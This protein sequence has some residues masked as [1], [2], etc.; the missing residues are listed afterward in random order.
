LILYYIISFAYSRL[1]LEAHGLKH[2]EHARKH[3]HSKKNSNLF[4]FLTTDETRKKEQHGH[5]G[6]DGGSRRKSNQEMKSIQEKIKKR[7]SNSTNT[8]AFGRMKKPII[9]NQRNQNM[10]FGRRRNSTA[11]RESFMHLHQGLSATDFM[12]GTYSGTKP[13]Y[14]H[15]LYQHGDKE[16]VS[17]N[18]RQVLAHVLED[19]GDKGDYHRR[20]YNHKGAL[21]YKEQT[22]VDLHDSV[23]MLEAKL[24]A[25]EKELEVHTSRSPKRSTSKK[26]SAAE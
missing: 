24:S 12:G 21:I 15:I 1:G 14:N 5:N 16:G 11:T 18:E 6:Q 17:D 19:K 10:A 23:V 13:T 9:S 2:V 4:T 22:M 8:A 26:M 25:K 20:R 3:H 7:N